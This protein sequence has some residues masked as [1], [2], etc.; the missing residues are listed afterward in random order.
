MA[1]KEHSPEYIL[2]DNGAK[3]KE[4]IDKLGKSSSV[5]ESEVLKS[6]ILYYIDCMMTCVKTISSQSSSPVDAPVTKN[7]GSS[8]KYTCMRL[9]EV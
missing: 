9:D 2:A 4:M 3:A 7:K 1:V 6:T 5:G 8:D